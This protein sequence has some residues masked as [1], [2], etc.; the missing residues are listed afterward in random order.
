[1]FDQE[2]KAALHLAAEQ[3]HLDVC[4][5]L[6]AHKAFVNSRSKI[7]LTALHLAAMHGYT[8][9]VKA[10]IQKHNAAVDV[11]TLVR[12]GEVAQVTE[13]MTIYDITCLDLIYVIS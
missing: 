7:G 8:D 4:N 13:G 2:G 11:N 5:D 3:G 12:E 6:L 9:L 10:L 1:M